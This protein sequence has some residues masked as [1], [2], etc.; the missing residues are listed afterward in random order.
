MFRLFLSG[1]L[2][3]L[4]FSWQIRN[5]NI[6]FWNASVSRNR[7]YHIKIKLNLYK[8]AKIW[9]WAF[10]HSCFMALNRLCCNRGTPFFFFTISLWYVR[11]LSLVF[12]NK[13]Y[14]HCEQLMVK[15][16]NKKKKNKSSSHYVTCSGPVWLYLMVCVVSATSTGPKEIPIPMWNNKLRTY[17]SEFQWTLI[18]DYRAGMFPPVTPTYQ[19]T[20]CDTNHI[21][22][23]S[24]LQ[25]LTR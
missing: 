17:S 21:R 20:Q 8:T 11:W 10:P 19:H 12:L 13:Q 5:W 9:S 3:L 4:S 23:N 24:T 18:W 2:P 7:K 22:H 1:N 25:K 6:F 16:S 15:Q 14:N